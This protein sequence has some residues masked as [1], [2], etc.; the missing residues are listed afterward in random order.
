MYFIYVIH[1]IL[2]YN[3]TEKWQDSKSLC[4]INIRLSHQYVCISMLA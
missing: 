3:I 2:C 4:V 1:Y